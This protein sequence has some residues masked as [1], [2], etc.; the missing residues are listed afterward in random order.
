MFFKKFSVT[1]KKT[2]AQTPAIR[3]VHCI[4]YNNELRRKTIVLTFCSIFLRNYKYF[5]EAATILGSNQLA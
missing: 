2:L 3:M 5:K 1:T 4:I